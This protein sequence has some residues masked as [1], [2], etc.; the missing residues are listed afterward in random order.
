[1][2]VENTILDLVCASR[3]C[4]RRFG[5]ITIQ[6]GIWDRTALRI[7]LQKQFAYQLMALASSNVDAV[8]GCVQWCY[9]LGF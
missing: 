2:L 3:S 9:M 8:R 4:S 1:M 5:G 7:T 6:D